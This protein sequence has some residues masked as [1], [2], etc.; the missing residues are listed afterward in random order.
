[1]GDTA[2]QVMRVS[3]S[4][5]VVDTLTSFVSIGMRM[6]RSDNVTWLSEQQPSSNTGIV[7]KRARARFMRFKTRIPSGT[8]WHNFKGID[9]PTNPAGLR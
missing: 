7:R 9:V 8:V 6:R 2:G 1:M 3:E 5:P 4:T